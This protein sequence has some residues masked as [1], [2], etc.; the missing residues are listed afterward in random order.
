MSK[1]QRLVDLLIKKTGEGTADWQTTSR[2]GVFSLSLPDF[3][4]WIS[5][6]SSDEGSE[7]VW[8]HLVNSQGAVIDKIRDIDIAEGIDDKPAFYKRMDRLYQDARRQAF[9][10]DQALDKLIAELDN[11]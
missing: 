9:G 10:V 2:Q 1:Y 7:D 3:S 11:A 5:R 6:L 4:V 8:L